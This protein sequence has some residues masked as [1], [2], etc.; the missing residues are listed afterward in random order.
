[1]R[2]M[3]KTYVILG[4]FAL[5]GLLG[6]VMW[7]LS[8]ESPPARPVP[9]VASAT[10]A[11]EPDESRE[12]GAR[13]KPGGGAVPSAPDG[14]ETPDDGGPPARPDA[15]A[16]PVEAGAA[17]E[18]P[19]PA[20]D[21][22]WR[23]PG[24]RFRQI[25]EIALTPVGPEDGGAGDLPHDQIPPPAVARCDLVLGEVPPGEVR[26]RVFDSEGGEVRSRLVV[27]SNGGWHGGEGGACH[28]L[29]FE[30]KTAAPGSRFEVYYPMPREEGSPELE[31]GPQ[32]D[33]DLLVTVY[34]A[35][36]VGKHVRNLDQIVKAIGGKKALGAPRRQT[37]IDD[38]ESPYGPG[39]HYAA[40]YQAYLA[41]P[42]SGEYHF[43][44]D[45]D[46]LA[47]LLVDGRE[48]LKG[49]RPGHL[50]DRP[51]PFRRRHSLKAG[52]HA[53]V[54]YHI[55]GT[56]LLRAR[57][58]WQ[59][60]G[61]SGMRVIP[62]SAFVSHVQARPVS[63]E[64]RDE[65]PRTRA[66]FRAEPGR[67]LVVNGSV[68][69]TRW[70]L[71]AA[72]LPDGLPGAGWV[73]REGGTD[74][75]EGPDLEVYVSGLDDE[76]T[77]IRPYRD[78]TLVLESR[79]AARPV[80]EPPGSPGEAG[81]AGKAARP[82]EGEAAKE[83]E[84]STHSSYTRRIHALETP[85]VEA[86]ELTLRLELTSAS[87][88]IH[89]RE[90][91]KLA[92]Q[93]VNDSKEAVSLEATEL[94]WTGDS[95]GGLAGTRSLGE[96]ELPQVGTQGADVLAR[97]M[98][99]IA[100]D[101]SPEAYARLDRLVYLL[102]PPRAPAVKLVVDLLPS[103]EHVLPGLRVEADRFLTDSGARAIFVLPFDRESDRRRFAFLRRLTE[104]GGDS[105]KALLY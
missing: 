31:G 62:P 39:N 77:G 104:S 68:P 36:A 46:D 11:G 76:A 58:A 15:Q 64:D 73:W 52:L 65:R 45:A 40:V 48:V 81:E 6:Y 34:E 105:R 75:G 41:C 32:P 5:G 57:L 59:P 86:E 16:E 78:I 53:I 44:I 19:P 80:D 8:S 69:V 67:R 100:L 90:D 4:A 50:P 51:F 24:A 25:V 14:P 60:P 74:L 47:V 49:G 55:Q 22:S 91:L 85:P 84:H 70:K 101:F 17:D 72:A 88:F 23:V 1:M 2:N 27:R 94:S 12:T 98:N 26:V 93:A 89:P 21:P 10:P 99:V 83:V 28:D 103:R 3:R 35:R 42:R 92:L 82:V 56:E 102:G 29:Y 20:P 95:P 87:N 37:H 13:G 7:L 54:L 9:E 33:G 18:E 96:F 38:R 71:V 61:A 30:A 43:G 63:L 97:R 79:P 66:F